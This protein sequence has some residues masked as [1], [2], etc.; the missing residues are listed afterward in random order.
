[1]VMSGFAWK[2]VPLTDV[3]IEDEFWSPRLRINR[4]QTIPYEY[5]QCKQTGRIDAGV[6]HVQATGKRTLLDV[7][8]RYADHIATVFGTAPG[9]KRGYCGHEEIELAL[10]KLYR[11]TGEERYL[12]LSQYFVDER[13]REPYYFDLE[14]ARRGR[15]SY[16]EEHFKRLRLRTLREYNQSHKPV[17]EQREVVG[18]AVRAMYLYSAMADL[19][20]ETGDETL[21]AACRRLWDHLCATRLYITAGLGSSAQNEG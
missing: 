1:M 18:H 9:Q 13:G 17:R 20:G 10:V 8:S 16:F 3:R 7:V 12:R 15:P 14:A 21:L 19:T 6:A 2:P 5:R 4:E 11:A